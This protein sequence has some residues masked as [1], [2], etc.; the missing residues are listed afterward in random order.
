[1][2]YGYDIRDGFQPL[3]IRRKSIRRRIHEIKLRGHMGR[4]HPKLCFEVIGLDPKYYNPITPQ[5][6]EMARLL[7]ISAARQCRENGDTEREIVINLAWQ[8]LKGWRCM[9]CGGLK[10]RTRSL[11]CGGACGKKL[12]AR[13]IRKRMGPIILRLHPKNSSKPT[14]TSYVGHALRRA[15]MEMLKKALDKN[16]GNVAAAARELGMRY[17][18]VKYYIRK[19]GGYHHTEAELKKGKKTL[20]AG[21]TAVVAHEK[22][23]SHSLPQ[24]SIP[25]GHSPVSMESENNHGLGL[26]NTPLLAHGAATD[27]T[28]SHQ[29]GGES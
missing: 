15:Q 20:P 24:T 1:M 14:G 29:T 2:S 26:D 22:T 17:G 11:T 21:P 8:Y 6:F 28:T 16:E 3:A 4:S 9:V 18:L 23:C 10:K 27:S 5:S 13:A 7:W 19:F 12:I 25:S